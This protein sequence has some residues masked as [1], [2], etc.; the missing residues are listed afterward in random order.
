MVMVENKIKGTTVR[1][2][3]IKIIRFADDTTNIL[4]GTEDSLQVTLNVLEIFGN[5][6]GLKINAEKA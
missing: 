6:S 4:D 3:E 5:I 2:K 1:Q